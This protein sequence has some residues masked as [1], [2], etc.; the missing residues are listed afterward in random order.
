MKLKEEFLKWVSGK[1]RSQHLV[2]DD[3]FSATLEEAIAGVE[4]CVLTSAA[5]NVN[6]KEQLFT[7]IMYYWVKTTENVLATPN[8]LH[9]EIKMPATSSAKKMAILHLKNLQKDLA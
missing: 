1:T 3:L 5:F 6:S 2:I 4:K 8:V 9:K 7:D